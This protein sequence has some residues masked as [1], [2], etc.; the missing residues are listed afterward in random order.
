MA[1]TH[2]PWLPKIDKGMTWPISR[3]H[4]N[5]GWRRGDR[6]TNTEGFHAQPRIKRRGWDEL[7]QLDD[8]TGRQPTIGRNTS[9]QD[10]G[11]QGG[12]GDQRRAD[13]EVPDG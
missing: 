13:Q 7:S 5:A 12:G 6:R 3:P 1:V 2:V 4:G 10:R 11:G 9:E 8:R